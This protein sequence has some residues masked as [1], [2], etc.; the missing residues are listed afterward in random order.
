MTRTIRIGMLLT[1]IGLIWI[2]V[3]F[4][5]AVIP[6]DT[7]YKGA[8]YGNTEVWFAVPVKLDGS[9][10][11]TLAPADGVNMALLL[12]TPEKDSLVTSDCWGNPLT[13]SLNG[14]KPD[15]FYIRIWGYYGL[16]RSHEYTLTTGFSAA[17]L[18]NDIEPND[19]SADAKPLPL[20]GTVTGHIGY[21]GRLASNP[22]DV[23]DWWR[24]TTA[25]DGA[26]TVAITQV[27]PVNL[28]LAFYR[29]NGDSAIVQADTWGDTTSIALKNLRDGTY[30]VRVA[31]YAWHFSPY[32]LGT[33]FTAAPGGNDPE[34]NNSI[35]DASELTIGVPSGGH[36]GYD[37]FRED[38]GFDPADWW[39]FTFKD[40][41][42]LLL[43]MTQVAT[44]NLRL[45]LYKDDGITLVHDPG[46]TWG[47]GC[48]LDISEV[49]PGK[50]YYRVGTYA[51]FDSYVL[52]LSIPGA[53]G[54]GDNKAEQTSELP[55]RFALLQNYPNPFNPTTV[56]SY[57]LPVASSVRLVVYDMLG[58]DV[59]V[60]VN[61][62]KEPGNYEVQFDGSG[63]SS[64][65]YFYRL[66]AGDFVS[67][68][69]ML[70][71]R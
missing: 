52:I 59:A 10:S 39:H 19:S 11:V 21:D 69:R 22:A 25:E 54:T 28:Q 6:P 56:I 60:L 44:A 26:L 30:F 13:L 42:A 47:K 37:G 31:K 49:L 57:Q 61:E 8:L 63:L 4:A 43:R 12:C 1:S 64:G 9:L 17:A 16:L 7:T 71:I 51:A 33:A 65:V 62:K 70:L 15:T 29:P 36:L 34:P 68:K 18:E 55:A 14:V 66:T 45:Q 3:V 46:D 32:T 23:F 48:D 35:G 53:T 41:S 67:T 5:D 40:T 24:I 2:G 50:Y 20:N 38:H 27:E 58:R